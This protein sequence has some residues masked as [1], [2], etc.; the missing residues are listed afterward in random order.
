MYAPHLGYPVTCPWRHGLLPTLAAVTSMALHVSLWVFF[1][2]TLGYK[3]RSGIPGSYGDSTF[4]FLMNFCALSTV[5]GLFCISTNST[6]VLISPHR[7]QLPHIL[8]NPPSYFDWLTDG[9]LIAAVLGDEK[10]TWRPSSEWVRWDQL[11]LGRNRGQN[12][13]RL[14]GGTLGVTASEPRV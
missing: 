3:P 14:A 1:S 9:Y 4:K 6:G 11:T 10:C 8:T 7:H 2:S 12:G 13:S 5:A